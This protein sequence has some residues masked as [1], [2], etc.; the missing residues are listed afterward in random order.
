MSLTMSPAALALVSDA[1]AAKGTAYVNRVTDESVRSAVAGRISAQRAVQ[2]KLD[3]VARTSAELDA[4]MLQYPAGYLERVQRAFTLSKRAKAVAAEWR[5]LARAH[6]F[7]PSVERMRRIAVLH[8][9]LSRTADSYWA[10]PV[11]DIDLDATNPHNRFMRKVHANFSYKW[12]S[13]A[14]ASVDAS[15]V[16]QTAVELVLRESGTPTIGKLYQ[17]LTRAY[18]LEQRVAFATRAPGSVSVDNVSE[19]AYNAAYEATVARLE[20]FGRITLTPEQL[21]DD[22]YADMAGTITK[23]GAR[24]A[25]RADMAIAEVEKLAEQRANLYRTKARNDMRRASLHTLESAQEELDASAQYGKA[26]VALLVENNTLEDVAQF[27]GL[28]VATVT[29]YAMDTRKESAPVETVTAKETPIIKHSHWNRSRGPVPM[30][31][32][33]AR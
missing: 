12:Q 3:G 14:W 11:A 16:F 19:I 15:D 6:G 28:T 24:Y 22:S 21:Q 13:L 17:A 18:K 26:I 20:A 5:K 30:L 2:A 4:L 25:V 1:L 23:S 33:V 8:S 9:H 31:G 27:F 29:K 10:T 32:K 7:A